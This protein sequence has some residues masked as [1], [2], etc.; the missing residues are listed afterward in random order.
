VFFGF[1]PVL[2]ELAPV[3]N[4]SLDNCLMPLVWSDIVEKSNFMRQN[5]QKEKYVSNAVVAAKLVGLAG[6]FCWLSYVLPSPDVGNAT[7]NGQTYTV[8]LPQNEKGFFI[9]TMVNGLWGATGIVATA[10]FTTVI[11]WLGGLAQTGGTALASSVG[12]VCDKQIHKVEKYHEIVLEL[13]VPTVSSAREHQTMNNEQK[14]KQQEIIQTNIIVLSHA[15]EIMLA[16]MILEVELVRKQS[17]VSA[18]AA[19]KVLRQIFETTNQSI[20]IIRERLE[21]QEA[22]LDVLEHWSAQLKDQGN[23]FKLFAWSSDY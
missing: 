15:V 3:S 7:K 23:R 10:F 14:I 18:N 6:I 11:Y 12:I 4:I 8:Q 5:Q 22:V 21:K 19:F 2:A 1:A 9:R 20:E 16:R 17:R 13:T